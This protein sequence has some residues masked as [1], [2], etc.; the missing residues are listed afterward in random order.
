MNNI[1][2]QQLLKALIDIK[3]PKT[4]KPKGVKT[5]LPKIN[6]IQYRELLE[7]LLVVNQP[8]LITGK[9]GIGKTHLPK[10]FCK[11]KGI[12][13]IIF[14][15]AVDTP[16]DYKG[17]GARAT[18]MMP[19]FDKPLPSPATTELDELDALLLGTPDSNGQLTVSYEMEERPVAE[20][21]PYG[22]MLKLLEATRLTYVFFDDLGQAPASVQSA[23]MQVLGDRELAGKKIPDCVRFIAATNG[24]EHKAN[25]KGLLEPVKSRFGCIVELI[26]D[27]QSWRNDFCIEANVYPTIPLF[28]EYKPDAFCQFSPSDTMENSP[29]PRLWAKLS[30]QLHWADS[31]KAS[32]EIRYILCTGSV[33]ETY[34]AQYFKFEALQKQLPPISDILADPETYPIDQPLDVRYAMLGQLATACNENTAEGIF[35]YTGKMAK[36]YQVTFFRLLRRHNKKALETTPA[37]KWWAMNLEIYLD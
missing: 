22:Q 29:N 13:L 14:H 19:N 6:Y 26:E 8:V 34:G 18:R 24:R 27:L 15:P 2:V 36:E 32:K 30:E 33:G 12:D 7:M 21:L 3:Q 25:V 11:E 23:L 17:L 4:I 16:Q 37:Q 31:A 5:M 9:P 28:F 1:D 35:K 10:K 20:H